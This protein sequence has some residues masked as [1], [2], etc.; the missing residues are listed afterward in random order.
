MHDYDTLNDD[1]TIRTAEDAFMVLFGRILDLRTR[2]SGVL[3]TGEQVNT[4]EGDDLN[5]GR[6]VPFYKQVTHDEMQTIETL[7]VRCSPRGRMRL[8]LSPGEMRCIHIRVSIPGNPKC[9]IS[10]IRLW[11]IMGHGMKAAA[12]AESTTN[13][14]GQSA[15]ARYSHL[16]LSLFLIHAKPRAEQNEFT[17]TAWPPRDREGYQVV[18]SSSVTRS[19]TAQE[20]TK[21]SKAKNQKQNV[22]FM[23][24]QVVPSSSAK[25]LNMLVSGQVLKSGNERSRSAI[26]HVSNEEYIRDLDDMV[27]QLSSNNSSTEAGDIMHSTRRMMQ[28]AS[29]LGVLDLLAE[30]QEGGI[31]HNALPIDITNPLRIPLLIAAC[32]RLALHP[33]KYNL[34]HFS[35][36]DA[37]CL[38][39]FEAIVEA[40]WPKCDHDSDNPALFAIDSVFWVAYNDTHTRCAQSVDGGRNW[41]KCMDEMQLMH[42]LG[43]ALVRD[44][45]DYYVPTEFANY[46]PFGLADAVHDS[47]AAARSACAWNV[48][49][50]P[51]LDSDP[52]AKSNFDPR[53]P[54]PHRLSALLRLL[55]E[56]DNVLRTGR[57]DGQSTTPSA[58]IAVD[59][60]SSQDEER[61]S[62]S[63]LMQ[64]RLNN[65]AMTIAAVTLSC[66]MKM[67]LYS[68][69]EFNVSVFALC[70]Q[71]SIGR[72]ADCD[73]TIS[74]VEGVA[75]GTQHNR[76]S[77]CLTRRCFGCAAK[78][79]K[80]EKFP[81]GCMRCMPAPAAPTPGS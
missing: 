78:V 77:G 40:G 14:S 51:F 15:G 5:W 4:V 31:G 27:A 26:E 9:T 45:F 68:L 28:H 58:C 39:E 37:A 72:C 3:W 74:V 18:M 46:S 22:Q 25:F 63:D 69:R 16:P 70:K 32:V 6:R 47:I 38:R 30:S 65:H 41:A 23:Q 67:G 35:A 2:Y 59:E 76:C 49:D 19:P 66:A 53:N 17:Y 57:A 44:V 13:A 56:V 55:N 54:R 80:S 7:Q 81:R 21:L 75:F 42:R 73:L 43:V 71:G 48:K 36:D 10:V 50:G 1:S 11:S 34:R 12:S 20:L 60:A 52:Q 8:G 79:M 29:F 24:P 64:T 61:P 62:Q 33:T